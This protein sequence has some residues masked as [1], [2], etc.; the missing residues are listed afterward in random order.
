MVPGRPTTLIS[1]YCFLP[2][3]TEIVSPAST[4]VARYRRVISGNN[5]LYSL[6]DRKNQYVPSFLSEVFSTKNNNPLGLSEF[7]ISFATSSIS[8]FGIAPNTRQTQ[9]TSNLNLSFHTTSSDSSMYLTLGALGA[10]FKKSSERSMPTAVPF[11]LFAKSLVKRPGPQPKSRIVCS[12]PFNSEL[13][14]GKS[15]LFCSSVTNSY[16][17]SEW[18]R[19]KTAR[20]PCNFTRFS[21]YA[22]KL[23]RFLLKKD[24]KKSSR[25]DTSH[26][27]NNPLYISFLQFS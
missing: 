23:F 7:E 19:F 15:I 20:L 5:A 3:I 11:I 4:Y 17:S 14:I 13:S 25:E 12:E 16:S 21:Q 10:N 18:F 24:K 26:H 22:G 1:H 27:P 9:I 8:N 6:C 2:A